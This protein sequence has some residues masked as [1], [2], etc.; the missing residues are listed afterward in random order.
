[1]SVDVGYKNSE[2]LGGI[3]R[4]IVRICISCAQKERIVGFWFD[5]DGEHSEDKLVREAVYHRRHGT[6]DRS[7]SNMFE[8]YEAK[9][10]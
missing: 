1:M 9:P 5:A 7:I 2:L 8:F 10:E 3:S 4:W 6:K